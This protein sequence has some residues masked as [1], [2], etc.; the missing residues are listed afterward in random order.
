MT[1]LAGL[2]MQA[3]Y[4][5]SRHQVEAGR[6]PLCTASPEVLTA[7]LQARFW[8]AMTAISTELPAAAFQ[9]WSCFPVDAFGR[10]VDRERPACIFRWIRDGFDPAYL[11]QDSAGNLYGITADQSANFHAAEDEFRLGLQ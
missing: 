3:L 2:I 4:L 8:Q 6:K 11:V 1:P 10:P 7:P 5:S 9:R